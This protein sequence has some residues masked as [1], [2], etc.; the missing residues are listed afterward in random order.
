MKFHSRIE[1]T[2]KCGSREYFEEGGEDCR[3]SLPTMLKIARKIVRNE[4]YCGVEPGPDVLWNTDYFLRYLKG[5]HDGIP[6]EVSAT[7]NF[8]YV[9]IYAE[10]GFEP[11][12]I[13]LKAVLPEFKAALLRFGIDPRAYRVEVDQWDIERGPDDSDSH[14][15][16][17]GDYDVEEE[18]EDA[19]EEAE[20][21]GA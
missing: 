7:V 9:V 12:S 10:D 21:P 18:S 1:L 15:F 2:L 5:K 8:P 11:A 6:C 19:P 3:P 20:I 4:Y 13:L 17:E 16:M 14:D